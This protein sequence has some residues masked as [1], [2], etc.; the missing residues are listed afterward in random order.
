MAEM[1]PHKKRRDKVGR[2]HVLTDETLQVRYSH[3]QLAQLAAEGGADVAQYREKRTRAT[4]EMVEAARA[5]RAA[6]PVGMQLVVDDRLRDR[7][8]PH[9]MNPFLGSG[10]DAFP[11]A[12]AISRTYHSEAIEKPSSASICRFGSSR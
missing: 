11:P 8:Q 10:H 3:L 9:V 6:L 7:V 12:Q 2:F 5:L 1:Q 4:R